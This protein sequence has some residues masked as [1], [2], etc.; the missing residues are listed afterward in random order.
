M[1]LT[2]IALKH[3]TTVY[4]ALVCVVVAG[5]LSYRS[6]PLEAEPEVQIPIVLVSTIYPGVAPEDVERLV[7]NVLERQLKTLK[8]VDKITSSSAE[9]VSVIDIEF[10][11]GVDIDSAFQKVRAEVDK[12]KGDLPADVEDPMLIEINISDF[13]MMLV[14]V[15]GKYGLDR[16]KTVGDGLKD[17][18]EEVPGVLAADLVGGLERE[19]QIYLDPA[20]LEHYGLSVDQVIMRVQQEHRSTPAG[21]LPLHGTKYAV[22]IPG[23]YRDVALMEDIV[24]DAPGGNPIRLKDVGRVI[25]GHKDQESVSRRDGTECVTLRV[26]KQVGANIIETADAVRAALEA[27]RPG[28]PPGTEIK[29]LQDSSEYVRDTFDELQNTIISSIILVLAVLLFAMGVRNAIFAAIAVP[30]SML[31]SFIVLQALGITIN[32]V[33]MFGFILVLGML[34]DDSIVVVEN[35]YRHASEGAPRDRAA[36]EATSEVAWPVI[37]STLTNMAVFAPLLLWPGIMGD[38]MSYL[39]ITVIITLASSLFVALVINPVI[40]ARFLKVRGKMTFDESGIATG[41][42]SA[43]YQKVLRWSLAHPKTVLAAFFVL[44]FGTVVVYGKYNA[45]VEFFPEMTPDSVQVSVVAP[46][47]TVLAETDALVKRVEAIARTEPNVETVVANVGTGGSWVDTGSA[48]SHSAVVDVE[49]KKKDKRVSST[50]DTIASLREKMVGLPGAEYRVDVASMGP[51]TG[52]AVSI[53]LSGPDYAVLS[54]LAA[55]TRALIA[56]V[57]G[58]VDV[59]D[60]FEAGKPEIRVEVD[61]EKAM[62]RQVNTAAVSMAVRAAVNGVQASV[63]REGDETYDITVRYDERFRKSINDILD[64]RV[65]GGNGVQIPLRDV[66]RVYTTGGFG[67][68]NH[69]DQLRTVTVMAD[70]SGRSSSEIIPEIQKLL[71]AKLERPQGYAVKY[72][73]ESQEQDEASAFLGKALLYGLMLIAVILITQFNSVVRPAIIMGSVLLSFIGVLVCLLVTR[74]KFGVI[75]SGLG[76]IS[77]AG[78]VVKNAIVLI[79]YT[80]LLVEKRGLPLAEALARAGVVR[81]RPVILTAVAAVLGVLPVA[82]GVSVDFKHLDVIV[83]SSSAEMWGPL[84]QV[85]AFG[86]TFATVLTLIVVPVM[87]VAQDNTAKMLGR[88]GRRI[89][90]LG[91]RGGAA[92][93]EVE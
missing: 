54:R 80:N 39:P 92:R 89:R 53:E 12:A 55:R 72:S 57:P 76:V 91:P 17:R 63:L 18:L 47:G 74:G 82:F 71:A 19:I 90:G 3:R 43:R 51:P 36:L 9:S 34:V 14:N 30:I 27:A 49:F 44:L 11:T 67:S 50:W 8:N 22:R 62:E 93:A 41:R 83:G 42:F 23:E 84:A 65:A 25:D 4:V 21:N 60:D 58:V 33:V 32:M 64:I 68:I 77:L 85:L 88:L 87:Y 70:A 46:Q 31:M 45:G 6:L 73:G 20:R 86:L 1:S 40:A 26:K 61:R 66:A 10:K 59:K 15:S 38:F 24:V 5:L 16:L 48:P 52:A 35:I 28:F 79:D 29:I 37:T 56:T 7:T 81:L 69:I 13:P 78:V 75:M 2:G